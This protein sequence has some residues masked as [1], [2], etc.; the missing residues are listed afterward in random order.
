MTKK[1]W[2]KKILFIQKDTIRETILRWLN[3][4]H[5]TGESE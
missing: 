3:E 5:K 4:N 1:N 2:F